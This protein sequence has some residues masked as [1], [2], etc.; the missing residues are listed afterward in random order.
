VIAARS[1]ATA[2]VRHDRAGAPSISTVHAPQTPCSQP[3]CVA[4]RI[5]MLAQEIDEVQ[6]RLDLGLDAPSVDDE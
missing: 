1:A 6:S 5:L 4:V 2:N 3:I